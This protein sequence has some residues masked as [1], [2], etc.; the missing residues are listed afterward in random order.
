MHQG[1][2][3]AE[4]GGPAFTDMS[5]NINSQVSE[6]RKRKALRE[7][8]R[9]K[10]LH[11]ARALPAAL[12]G[13]QA[14]IQIAPLDM[15]VVAIV[16]DGMTEL[17]HRDHAIEV[18][19][20][21]LKHN[22]AN[23]TVLM[24]VGKL[25]QKMDM[26]EIAAKVFSAAIDLSPSEPSYYVNLAES[27][28]LQ[29]KLDEAV[30]LV[31]GA[32]EIFPETASLWNIMGT[33]MV[34]QRQGELAHTFYEEALR[35]DPE[36]DA[37]QLNLANLKFDGDDP[38]ALYRQAIT[39]NPDN[40]NAHVGLATYLLLHGNLPE[41]WQHYE[42]RK[43]TDSGFTSS[44]TFTFDLPQW[45]GE[46]LASKSIL[47]MPEQGLGDEI[48]FGLN[49]QRLYEEAGKLYIGCDPRLVS[50]LKR[51]FPRAIVVGFEDQRLEGR[52]YRSFPD[53][54]Q[55]MSKIDYGVWAGSLPKIWWPDIASMPVFEA[56][57]LKA[58]PDLVEK[59][60]SMAG[61][62]EGRL[63]IGISWRSGNLSFERSEF[64]IGLPGARQIMMRE[65]VDFFC[66]QYGWD[67]SEIDWLL[68]QTGNR[69]HTFPNLDLKNDLE[70]NLALMAH[71]DLVVGPATAT[72]QIAMNM[73]VPTWVLMG[74]AP[75]WSLGETGH[76]PAFAP[77]TAWTW[78]RYGLGQER[79]CRI[80]SLVMEAYFARYSEIDLGLIGAS[81]AR[82]L[83]DYMAVAQET[84][85]R[86][87][88][89]EYE[90]RFDE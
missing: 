34:N 90:P 46:P 52:R 88:T 12:K 2:R 41:G 85:V 11:L 4:Q 38:T 8:V 87:F 65:N 60:R 9:A 7:A 86:E 1:E 33:L 66:L 37:I 29:E 5:V 50:I 20:H 16:A 15:D 10:D 84:A 54:R 22:P 63:K 72:Q 69:L 89:M 3:A 79:M 74:G 64:Y 51:S 30:E 40:H 78:C 44:V 77:N 67:Q 47:V 39:A 24:I 61:S 83:D 80:L 43:E 32:L 19:Q 21:A 28:R 68:E 18:L 73:G 82:A 23:E 25:A 49:F 14:A 62:S 45:S 31:K 13:Y 17:G 42:H 55:E 56:G 26:P 76:G 57:F 36:N 58:D 70:A 71:M 35:L 53:L 59:F 81:A 75:W 48:F 27:Y 6:Q